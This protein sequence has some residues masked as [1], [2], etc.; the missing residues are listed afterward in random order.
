MLGIGGL[1]AEETALPML[2]P[3]D[4]LAMLAILLG[5]AACAPTRPGIAISEGSTETARY[6]VIVAMRPQAGTDNEMRDRI[7][8]AIGDG[9]QAARGIGSAASVEFIIRGDDGQTISV[10]QS[11]EAH[12]HPGERVILAGGEHSRIVPAPG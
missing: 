4:G 8:G 7:L 5:L 11:D 6:G 3:T 1:F 10:V 2:R 9:G 12:F